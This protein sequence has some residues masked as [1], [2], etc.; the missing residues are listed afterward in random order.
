[1]K[2]PGRWG[3]I[4]MIP[5]AIKSHRPRRDVPSAAIG[6]MQS[7]P[8]RGTTS[9]NIRDPQHQPPDQSCHDEIR[10]VWITTIVAQKPTHPRGGAG[11]LDMTLLARTRGRKANGASRA[12]GWYT[13]SPRAGEKRTPAIVSRRP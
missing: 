3:R 11:P 2:A 10:I 6:G 13:N 1:M 5:M 7:N 9:V 12:H 4:P 8:S